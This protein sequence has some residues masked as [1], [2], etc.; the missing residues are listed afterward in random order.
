MALRSQNADLNDLIR[1]YLGIFQLIKNHQS[2]LIISFLSFMSA[3]V[4]P[5]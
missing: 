2:D 4:T 1:A 5:A 3:F